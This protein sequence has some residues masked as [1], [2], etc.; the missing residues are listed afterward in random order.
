MHPDG[1]FGFDIFSKSEATSRR[2]KF[3][4]VGDM[5]VKLISSRNK[6]NFVLKPKKQLNPTQT[7]APAAP[8]SNIKLVYSQTFQRCVT[9][10]LTFS[11]LH[12][13]TFIVYFVV[14]K[15]IN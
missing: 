11:F 8:T 10:E 15:V 13:L 7:Q 14:D 12:I 9:T 3:K 6:I 1:K 2:Q 4:P 5:D